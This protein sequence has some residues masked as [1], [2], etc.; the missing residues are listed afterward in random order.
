LVIWGEVQTQLSE[1]ISKKFPTDIVVSKKFGREINGN[2]ILQKNN[3]FIMNTYLN[4]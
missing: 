3:G 2:N 1:L 4:F